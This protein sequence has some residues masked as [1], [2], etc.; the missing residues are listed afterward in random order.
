VN[1]QDSEG[2]TPLH[3]AAVLQNKSVTTML[4]D[5]GAQASMS[6]FDL[7][8]PLRIHKGKYKR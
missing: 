7:E 1:R 2:W 3:Y 8:T 4:L 6:N 5:N